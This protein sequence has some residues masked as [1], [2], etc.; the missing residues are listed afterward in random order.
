MSP[1]SMLDAYIYDTGSFQ[2]RLVQPTPEP[3]RETH[4][5]LKRQIKAAGNVIN[6]MSGAVA[7]H[8]KS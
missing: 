1:N 5:R 6:G 3:R 8:P 7:R 4:L 2:D